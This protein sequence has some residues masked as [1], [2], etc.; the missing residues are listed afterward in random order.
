MY[1]NNLFFKMYNDDVYNTNMDAD[2]FDKLDIE[3]QEA[4][5]YIIAIRITNDVTKKLGQPVY[6]GWTDDWTEF[7]VH[8]GNFMLPIDRGWLCSFDDLDD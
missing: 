8:R 3:D 1:E 7:D 5:M 4:T 2:V 6:L